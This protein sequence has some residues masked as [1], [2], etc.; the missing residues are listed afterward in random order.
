MATN[1]P[2]REIY[3]PR[4]DDNHL[5]KFSLVWLGA[6]ADVQKNQEMKRKLRTTI[7]HC[8]EFDDADECKNYIEQTSKDDRLVLLISNQLARQI[9]PSIHQLRQVLGIYIN[10][11]DKNNDEKWSREFPKLKGVNVEFNELI[12]QIN[13]DHSNQKKMEEP[14]WINMFTTID[15]AGK[16]TTGINGQFVF[17]QL[18]I[19]CL[20]RL[21]YNEMDKN[22]LISCFE[23]ECKGNQLELDRLHKFQKEYSRDKV[24]WWY[25]CDSFFY[26]T[27]NAALRKQNI[28]MMFLY[29]SFIIDMYHQ[30]EHY[31]SKSPVRVYRYQLM[32]IDE[33]SSLQK[34]I[35]QFVSVNSFLSTTN[36][37][38]IA[39]FYMGDRTQQVDLERVLFEIIADP[40]VVMTKPFADISTL[41]HFAD[42]SEVLFMLGSI[43]RINSII[44]DDEQV[45][46]IE[47]SLCGDDEHSL[48]HVLGDMKRKI[49]AGET[50]LCT[51]GK[52]L[53]TMGKFDLAKKY[54][55]RCVK[56]LSHN[57]PLLLIAY[58]DLANIATQQNQYEESIQW[59]QNLA[60]LKERM[61]SNDVVKTRETIISI[62]FGGLKATLTIF[63]LNGYVLNK[64]LDF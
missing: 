46:V 63:S 37:R 52:V 40:K 36:Q 20:L 35:G 31:Q 53:W 24:L 14:L 13:E 29:R 34:S 61:L 41:S 44:R 42:E 30:L 55:T 60:E 21:K 51:L 19:D 45:W 23:K 64:L 49:G 17:S 3:F 32:S 58:D 43:F 56:E 26:K 62:H 33:L 18:L 59:S 2:L 16:S 8:K 28:H 54:Y 9:V 38:E 4:S 57:D 27:L 50:T 10:S 39:E 25:T 12:S 11:E 6:N 47:M 22:E 1:I 5:E 48:K 15:D 7:N